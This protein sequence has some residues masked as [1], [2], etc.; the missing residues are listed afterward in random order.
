MREIEVLQLISDGLV[1]REIGQA[2]PL[3]GDGQVARP[4]PAGEAAG[5]LARPC[6]R[7]RLPPRHHRLAPVPMQNAG[8]APGVVQS[9]VENSGAGDHCTPGAYP[10]GALWLKALETF[11]PT[12]DIPPLRDVHALVDNA[13]CDGSTSLGCCQPS[14]R[15]A[16][17]ETMRLCMRMTPHARGLTAIKRYTPFG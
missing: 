16:T 14:R 13:E 6:G 2:L 9:S 7:R 17:I 1:N 4:P 12:V 5:A 10:P 15:V 8:E 11:P 3:R